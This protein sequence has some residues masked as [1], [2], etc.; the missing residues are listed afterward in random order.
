[1]MAV[2][3]TMAV[4]VGM[5]VAAAVISFVLVA[6]VVAVIM[7]VVMAVIMI[8][9]GVGVRVCG[10]HGCPPMRTSAGPA[11]WTCSSR[12]CKVFS[13]GWTR[14]AWKEDM[15]VKIGV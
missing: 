1:M 8:V 14:S 2:T 10:A 3:M 6:M 15:G 5:F 7:V 13:T 9:P 12:P 4:P 11:G